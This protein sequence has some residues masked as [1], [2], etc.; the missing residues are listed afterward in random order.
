MAAS[1][2]AEPTWAVAELFPTQGNWSEEEYLA[3]P[4]NRLMEFSNGFLELLPMPTTSHQVLV[5]YL[6]GLLFSFV[7]ERD[8]GKVL[9]APIRVRLW[10]GK[11]REPD[12]VFILKT[13]SRRIGEE[14]WDGADLAM[15][16]LSSDPKDRRRDIVTK[17]REYARAYGR[18]YYQRHRQH[19]LAK[20]LRR[21]R[22]SGRG[23]DSG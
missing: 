14:F 23:R 10:P 4:D 12:L 15:E 17:R 2:I 19:L 16:V 18:D 7:S 8:L 20:K 3:L 5:A 6:Y 13:H 1:K 21:T 11:F 9:F 22:S